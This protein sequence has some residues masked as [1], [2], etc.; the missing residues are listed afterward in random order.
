MYDNDKGHPHGISWGVNRI[1]NGISTGL[2]NLLNGRENS[3]RKLPTVKMLAFDDDSSV[4]CFSNGT[5]RTYGLGNDYKEELF[6]PR[7]SHPPSFLAIDFQRDSYLV[8][9]GSHNY[10]DLKEK[11]L[12]IKMKKVIENNKT[13]SS[14]VS[15][16]AMG[17]K[18]DSYFV[19][20]S[21]GRTFWNN[22]PE[23]LDESL[24]E[25]KRR[26]IPIKRVC[27]SAFD[28][29]YLLLLDNRK[30]EFQYCSSGALE[31]LITKYQ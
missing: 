30:R 26:K 22:L 27:L 17:R 18:E 7:K 16:A 9:V 25:A 19:S 2:H 1:S 31:T 13:D 29:R 3:E 11:N 4:I 24:K 15:W 12:P 20:F 21:D 10:M 14:Y 23:K 6:I 5:Y 8:D 28:D